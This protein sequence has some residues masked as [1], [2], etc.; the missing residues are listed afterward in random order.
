M[1]FV[2]LAAML[3]YLSSLDQVLQWNSSRASVPGGLDRPVRDGGT[4]SAGLLRLEGIKPD[5][6]LGLGRL[7]TGIAFLIFAISLVPGMFGGRLG[8][9]DAYVPAGHQSRRSA[10][11]AAKAGWPG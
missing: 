1:G 4:L 6:P 9:L 3:K 10:E 7:L 5:E 2:I 8:E 11:P